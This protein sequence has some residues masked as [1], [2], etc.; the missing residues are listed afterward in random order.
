MPTNHVKPQKTYLQ[1]LYPS[2]G[3]KFFFSDDGIDRCF[4][5]LCVLSELKNALRSGNLCMHGSRQF[6]DFEEYLLPTEKSASLKE[7][8]QSPIIL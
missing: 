7:A 4:Y 5:E 3:R 1:A 8:K 2:V 6:K